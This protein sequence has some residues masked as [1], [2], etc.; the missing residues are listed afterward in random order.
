MELK[1]CGGKD[2]GAPF[3]VGGFGEDQKG[4][5]GEEKAPP[6]SRQILIEK[7]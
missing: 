6:L 1:K 7:M 2:A 3:V 5:E 4:R